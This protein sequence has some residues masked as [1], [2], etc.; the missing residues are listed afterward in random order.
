MRETNKKCELAQIK[1]STR[2][3]NWL[4]VQFVLFAG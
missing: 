4:D 1:R 2:I 3:V